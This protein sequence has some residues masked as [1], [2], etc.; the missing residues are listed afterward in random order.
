MASHLVFIGVGLLIASCNFVVLASDPSPLQDL[1]V[2]DPN[3]P[4]NYNFIIPPLF[5]LSY[6]S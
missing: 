6:K 4:G 2:A 3:S 5:S 1:C